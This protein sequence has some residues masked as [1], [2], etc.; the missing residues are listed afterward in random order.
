MLDRVE[1]NADELETLQSR[2]NIILKRQDDL[3]AQLAEI[4]GV[5]HLDGRLSAQALALEDLRTRLNDTL[6]RVEQLEERL[7]R[8]PGLLPMVVASATDFANLKPQALAQM[9]LEKLAEAPPEQ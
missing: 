2:F 4:G 6:Y 5:G 7:R 3:E 1:V 8:G 9:L